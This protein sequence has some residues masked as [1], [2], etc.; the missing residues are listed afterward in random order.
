[1]N[2]FKD[3]NSFFAAVSHYISYSDTSPAGSN[4]LHSILRKDCV[5]YMRKHNIDKQYSD[6]YLLAK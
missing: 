1:M 6:Q 4:N 5:D 2:V 3:T